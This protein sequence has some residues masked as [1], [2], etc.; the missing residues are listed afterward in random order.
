MRQSLVLAWML[1]TGVMLIRIAARM[2]T[3]HR[4]LKESRRPADDESSNS[5]AVLAAI[6]GTTRPPRVRLTD[7]ATQ[8]FVWGWLR[9]NICLPLHFCKTGTVEQRR[10]VLAHEL[11]HVLRW[12][13]AV[14][15][16]QIVLQAVFFFHPLIW[17]AN[18]IIRQERE[19]C[20]DEIVL[21]TSC[22]SPKVYCEAIVNM[23]AGKCALRQTTPALAVT[24]PTKNIK[25]R[26]S[27][28]LTPNRVFRRRP[29]RAAVATILLV[30]GCVLPTALV[31]TTSADNVASQYQSEKTDSKETKDTNNTKAQDYGTWQA[32][33]VMDFRVLNADT[34]TPLADV[35][36]HLQNMGPGIDFHDVAIQK[37]DADGWS[38]IRLPDL[39]PFECIR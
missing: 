18:Q 7:S 11:A 13:A 27:T 24:G 26:I 33:Q 5:I 1:I 31:V 25:E 4:R 2:W 21:S 8:P 23:V 29:S 30:A 19:K 34:K 15:H 22:T 3:T 9:G 32:G 39:P 38:R 37:T 35:T 36:L 16:I 6:L 10:A 17:W 28:M 12:D 14:N 20:C